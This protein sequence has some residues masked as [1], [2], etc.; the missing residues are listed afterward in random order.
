M[1][2]ALKELECRTVHQVKKVI[3]YMLPG[4]KEPFYVHVENRSPQIVVHP[5]LQRAAPELGEIE[6]ARSKNSFYHNADMTRFPAEPHKGKTPC[7]F[8]WAFEFD[9]TMAVRSFI[10]GFLSVVKQTS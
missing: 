6:G 9:N 1:E 10:K 3:E 7:H 2:S 4:T 8:G 5:A